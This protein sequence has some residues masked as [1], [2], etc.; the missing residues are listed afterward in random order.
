MTQSSRRKGGLGRGSGSV[1]L[2]A[3]AQGVKSVKSSAK[4]TPAANR[5][6]ARRAARAS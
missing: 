6:P 1:G 4:A 3:R 5:V 2:G